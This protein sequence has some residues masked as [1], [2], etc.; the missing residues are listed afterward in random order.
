MGRFRAYRA[1]EPRKLT[2]GSYT[3]RNQ[4]GN[5]PTWGAF[6]PINPINPINPTNPINP[7]NPISPI[8]PIIPRNPINPKP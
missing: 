2:K 4:A 8:S 5:L 6:D 7:I 3:S 1:L